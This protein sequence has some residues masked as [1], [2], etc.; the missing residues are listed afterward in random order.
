ML[1]GLTLLRSSMEFIMN[2]QRNL[3]IWIFLLTASVLTACSSDPDAGNEQVTQTP[4]IYRTQPDV[5]IQLDENPESAV[6]GEGKP[7]EDALPTT[8]TAPAAKPSGQQGSQDYSG[9]SP[10]VLDISER[11]FDGGNALAVTFSVP[12]DP[13]KNHDEYLQVS[14]Q[15]GG[16]VDGGWVLSD[17]GKIAYFSHTKPKTSY[18][19]Q[20]YRGL[21]ASNGESLASTRSEIVSTRDIQASY[22]FVSQGSFLPLGVHSGLPVAT[23]NVAE[24][25]VNFHRVKP[26]RLPNFLQQARNNRRGYRYNMR[27]LAEH[28]ELVYSARYQFNA[29]ANKRREFNLPVQ[30][31]SALQQPG[32]YMAVMTEPGE[33]Y[34]NVQMTWF[35]VTDLGMH[36]RVYKDSYQVHVSSLKTAKPLAGVKLSLLDHQ[37]RIQT[38]TKT[39]PE[40]LAILDKKAGSYLLAEQGASVSVVELNGAA[41]DLSDFDLG[42]RPQLPNEL[43]IYGP[44][45]LYRPGETAQFSALLRNGDGQLRKAVPLQAKIKRPDGQVAKEFSWQ[46]QALAYYGYDYELPSNAQTGEWHLQVSNIDGG[47]TDYAFKVEEFLPER[48]KL[49]FNPGAAESAAFFNAKQ[50]IKVNILG[51][52]LYGAPAAGN[53]LQSSVRVAPLRQPLETLKDFQFGHVNEDQLQQSYSLDDQ[54]L[55]NS[56]LAEVEIE[57]RWQ[58]AKSPLAVTLTASLFE[59]GGRPVTRRHTSTVWPKPAMVGIR[60]SFK[61]KDPEANSRVSFELVR[62]NAKGEKLNADSLEVSLVREDRRYFWTFSN[63][64]GW[65][66]ESSDREYAEFTRSVSI[67][68]GQTAQLEAA[69]EWGAYRLEVRDP[70]YGTVSSVRFHA[71]GDWYRY[72]RQNELADQSARPDKVSLALDKESYKAGDTAVLSMVPP[73]AGEA[74]VLV[75]SDQPLFM[76]RISLPKEGGKISIPVD[77]DWQ[78]HDLYISVVH[79]QAAQSDKAARITPKRAFGLIHLPLNREPRRIPL[80]IYAEDKIVPNQRYLAKVQVKNIKAHRKVKLTLAAV[81]VGVLSITDFETP[82]PH[83]YFFEPRRYQID[84][85]DMYQKLI[86]LNDN[87]L[88]K[89]RFGGDAE[90]S[91]GGKQAQ[92]EVQIVSLFSGVVDVDADGLAEVPLDIPDFNGRLR[93]MAVAFS[94]D[95]FGSSEKEITVAAPLVTQLAMPRFL[96]MGDQSTFA[97]DV[98]NLTDAAQNL[99][100]SLSASGP[101]SLDVKAQALALK[102]G[103]KATLV[104]PVI[105]EYQMGRSQINVS[106]TGM[107][108]Y[109]VERDWGIQVRSAYPALTQT[110]QAWLKPSEEFKLDKAAFDA[111]VPESVEA[112]VKLNNS[113]DLNLRQQM[114]ELLRYPYG[115]LEQSTSSTYPW[116]FATEKNLSQMGLRNQTGKGRL[117]SIEHGMQR[118]AQKQ[119]S[120]GGY[121]L[122]SNRDGEAQWLTAYV[123]DF[124]TDARAQ[125]IDVGKQQYDKTM[126]RLEAY[127]AKR[128]GNFAHPWSDHDD[129]YSLAYRAYAAYVLSRHKKANLSKLRSLLKH[130]GDKAQSPLPLIHLGLA[131]HN[132]GDSQQGDKVLDKA[133]AMQR[134]DRYYADYGSDIRDTALSIHLLL[135]HQQRMEQAKT[136][137]IELADAIQQRRY[138][139]TQERNTLFLAGLALEQRFAEQW[140]ADMEL[141]D[142]VEQLKQ[143]GSFARKYEH[144]DL[145]QGI[146]I[147]NQGEGDLWVDVDYQG[148][149]TAAPEVQSSKNLS[150]RR[151]YFNTKGQPIDASRLT[152]GD[153]V[154]VRLELGTHWRTPDAMVI[155]LLPAGLELENQNLNHAIK[156]DEIEFERQPV[157]YWRERTRIVHQEYRDD[158]YVA[159]VDAGYH[160]SNYLFYLARAVTPGTYKVPAPLVEDMYRPED[161]AIGST[162]DSMTIVNP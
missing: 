69:V 145:Q 42:S 156:L 147:Q 30:N 134:G 58:Q 54:S 120:N 78:R 2:N 73:Q 92:A 126:K 112:V 94:E 3:I 141:N 132:Q 155:D 56:G 107:E 111:M 149:G 152:V 85:R 136:L 41:L 130:D 20:V 8:L 154:L 98:H 110:Q 101:V 9:L 159:A 25:D 1:Y 99:A 81:D 95:S 72:W 38:S 57:S 63:S 21:T 161:R 43:F 144:T 24:V 82:Q 52:Y 143:A 109:P 45:D 26:Q 160:N 27:A 36:V 118:I 91:R 80:A 13:G 60:P 37:G 102:A 70:E 11:S 153:L 29:P 35:A 116:L 105:A 84:S 31:L 74:L 79:L 140:Q 67:A 15:Q 104:Y 16:V 103:E 39:T 129:H 64:R 89:Q 65:H 62:A 139:S 22:S 146:R 18:K 162:I 87:P 33:Y 4:D 75:E 23:V 71:G 96:A 50:A 55:S 61:D 121:G 148:Y 83:R 68:A 10:E 51:E 117:S 32:V 100:V 34:D 158:R 88:A 138:L 157:S 17:S 108:N 93:L 135:R 106:I 76:Q 77:K 46:P 48:M 123:A 12:L 115:C 113:I 125:G 127:V 133:L 151:S 119:L 124:L 150:I 131:L 28:S 5:V 44:R 90:L 6:T 97:L 128:N 47:V 49:S 40:G 19:V 66:Y 53:R 114:N 122:W 137:G 59:S 142:A 14:Y 86:E 7:R